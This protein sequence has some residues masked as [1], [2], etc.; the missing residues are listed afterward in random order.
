MAFPNTTPMFGRLDS[1]RVRSEP[2]PENVDAP[3][4][5]RRQLF[6]FVS[7][8]RSAVFTA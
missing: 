1:R 5:F 2:S 3:E 6:P 7:A 8:G 4:A